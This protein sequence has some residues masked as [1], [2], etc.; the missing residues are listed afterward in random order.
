MAIEL[1]IDPGLPRGEYTLYLL[2]VP[3]EIQQPL[4][5]PE[6]WILGVSTFSVK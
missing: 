6:Q 1:P 4:T 3:T 2:R 5:Q